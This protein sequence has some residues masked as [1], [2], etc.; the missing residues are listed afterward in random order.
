MAD[1]T[2]RERLRAETEREIRQRA[3]ALLIEHGREAV[4][5]RAIAR[6]LGITAPALYRYYD[7][8]EHLLRQVCDDI[9]ADMAEGLAKDLSQLPEEDTL[10]RVF[11]VCR[12]FRRWALAHP[13]EF[14][15]VFASP[16]PAL[17]FNPCDAVPPIRDQFGNIFMTV[18]G[19][20]LSTHKLATP[21][22][23]DV[24]KELHDD[25]LVFRDAL[26]ETLASNGIAVSTEVLDLGTVYFMLR[27][28]IRLYGQVALEVFGR[29][30]LTT[31]SLEP[32]FELMLRELAT[33]VGLLT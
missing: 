2:R 33:E 11:A 10:G 15:L 5:L 28:W 13:E 24:P 6:E 14:A 25:L 22:E 31:A 17:G 7:S 12:G 18:A 26:L 23:Q 30:P 32:M 8:R 9:C 1:I 29:S 16:K 21:A 20:V 3:R 19:R 4:T 27:F